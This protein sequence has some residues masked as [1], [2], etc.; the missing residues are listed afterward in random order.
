[1]TSFDKN[2]LLSL[3]N[4]NDI[5]EYLISSLKEFILIYSIPKEF[6]NEDIC[7]LAIEIKPENSRYIPYFIKESQLFI[8][9]LYERNRKY[10]CRIYSNNKSL[11]EKFIKDEDI[12]FNI[13]ESNINNIKILPKEILTESLLLRIS[14]F[15]Y[16]GLINFCKST[17]K[18]TK[19][20]IFSA[21]KPIVIKSVLGSA[22]L[23]DLNI[24]ILEYYNFVMDNNPNLI[25][26][27]N[28]DYRTKHFSMLAFDKN[29][30]NICF[31]PKIYR[32]QD[33]YIKAIK[34]NPSNLA[35]MEEQTFEVCKLAININ[36]RNIKYV[37]DR[38]DDICILSLIAM[39]NELC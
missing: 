24:D 4:K 23:K 22:I 8:K 27:L 36:Y 31:I 19:S 11:L 1:M 35:Y 13:V 10:F 37:N 2:K 7:L 32:T 39:E 34:Y 15:N 9:G 30:N 20:I 14:T 18:L 16:N 26:F 29:P 28:N 12:A 17:N 3:K 38:S 25:K 5:E 21:A 33:M 6:I